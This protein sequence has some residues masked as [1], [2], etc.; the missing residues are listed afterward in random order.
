LFQNYTCKKTKR[1]RIKTLQSVCTAI[2]TAYKC[3]GFNNNLG[4]EF[5]MQDST[6]ILTINYYLNWA[7]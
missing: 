7:I 1:I 4:N 6:Y 2:P 3:L 5:A